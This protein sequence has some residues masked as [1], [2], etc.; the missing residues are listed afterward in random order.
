MTKFLQAV[1]IILMALSL[2]IGL[3]VGTWLMFIG[4]WVDVITT[5]IAMVNNK[6]ASI[7][8]LGYGIGKII[9][10]GPVGVALGYFCFLFGLSLATS[11]K[12][13]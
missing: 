13:K 11:K 9:L 6:A 2:F 5:V 1:G 3:Y 7:S 10:A 8:T 4:G 12:S